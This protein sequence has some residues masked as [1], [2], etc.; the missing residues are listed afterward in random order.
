[1]QTD[2]EHPR[3][4]REDAEHKQTA[5]ESGHDGDEIA[6]AAPCHPRRRMVAR[7]T[8]P[9]TRRRDRRD[10]PP[11]LPGSRRMRAAQRR[12]TAGRP[13]PT[14]RGT[15]AEGGGPAIRGS[16]NLGVLP[17]VCEKSQ[18]VFSPRKWSLPWQAGPMECADPSSRRASMSSIL[19]DAW[20]GRG[21]QSGNALSLLLFPWAGATG[22]HTTFGTDARGGSTARKWM[23]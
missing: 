2:Y 4:K 23:Y 12:T 10:M 22:E 5:G 6:H 21:G 14:P 18:T 15:T 19:V 13:A 3:S 9:P 7:L 16:A 8:P 11:A 20:E 17:N 1:M